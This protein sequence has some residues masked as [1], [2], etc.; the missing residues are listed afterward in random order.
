MSQKY[1]NKIEYHDQLYA[2]KLN[3][4]EEMDKVLEIYR[5]SKLSQEETDNLIKLI[6]RSKILSVIKKNTHT[7][8]NFLQT[9]AWVVSLGSSKYTKKNLYLSFS[10]SSKN[11]KGGSTS[12]FTL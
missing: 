8:T 7:H 2:N 6:T 3:T 10:N 5:L 11:L 1:K 12:K 4:L 9:K